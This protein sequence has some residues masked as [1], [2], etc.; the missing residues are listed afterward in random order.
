MQFLSA[1]Q[2]TDLPHATAVQSP[3]KESIHLRQSQVLKIEGGLE[4]KVGVRRTY[5]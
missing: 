4:E 3:P 1:L 2:I 5:H